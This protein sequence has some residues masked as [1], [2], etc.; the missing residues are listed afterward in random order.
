VLLG[1]VQ[2]V[3]RGCGG[4]QVVIEQ[5]GQRLPPFG[6]RILA[7]DKV[8]G[9]GAQQVV[10]AIPTAACGLHQVRPG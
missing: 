3:H 2:G 10:H 5:P 9:I 4:G 6:L 8:G 7:S 1:R